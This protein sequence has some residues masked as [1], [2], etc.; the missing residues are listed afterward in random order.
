MS[1]VPT[2]AK[3]DGDV[4]QQANLIGTAGAGDADTASQAGA[5]GAKERDPV[6]YCATFAARETPA[7]APADALADA[8]ADAPADVDRGVALRRVDASSVS[9]FR[10]GK[11]EDGEK[12]K[13]RDGAKEDGGGAGG[14]DSAVADT[15]ASSRKD[16]GVRGA[17]SRT[18]QARARS[19]TAPG[20]WRSKGADADAGTDH[21]ADAL[22]TG[23]PGPTGAPSQHGASRRRP[24]GPPRSHRSVP[25]QQSES[26]P[27]QEQVQSTPLPKSSLPIHR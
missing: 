26:E 3:L 20:T 9:G 2:A 4:D 12:R 24:H 23:I 17:R 19:G 8:P 11:G 13:A 5:V 27:G 25:L 10:P 18:G 7:D 15:R 1:P 14:G 16:G 22:G 21:Q 6:L